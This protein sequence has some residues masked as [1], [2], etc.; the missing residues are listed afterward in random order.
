MEIRVIGYFIADWGF[1]IEDLK[2][3]I[4]LNTVKVTRSRTMSSMAVYA[5]N[6]TEPKARVEKMRRSIK[7][8]SIILLWT[9]DLNLNPA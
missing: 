9:S 6:S 2:I 4:A 3:G 1:G 5:H 7:P 8:A